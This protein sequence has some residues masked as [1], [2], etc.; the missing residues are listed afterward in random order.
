MIWIMVLICEII[1]N[2]SVL[3]IQLWMFFCLKSEL[4]GNINNMFIFYKLYF[5]K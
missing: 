5:S 1:E 4:E 3:I 2:I